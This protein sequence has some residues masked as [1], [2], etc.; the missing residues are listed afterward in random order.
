M[1]SHD[2][3]YDLDGSTTASSSMSELSK[4]TDFEDSGPPTR[5][6]FESRIKTEE[7]ADI[8]TEESADQEE[9]RNATAESSDDVEI[10]RQRVD[11]SVDTF[12]PPKYQPHLDDRPF[13]YESPLGAEAAE[14]TPITSMEPSSNNTT[15]DERMDVDVTSV[16]SPPSTLIRNSSRPS[17]SQSAPTSPTRPKMFRSTS[18]SNERRGEQDLEMA[19]ILVGMS[20]TKH[21]NGKKG[22]DS[23]QSSKQSVTSSV[24]I[25]KP[26]PLNQQPMLCVT[27]GYLRVGPPIHGQALRFFN[28]PPPG[29]LQALQQPSLRAATP[30]RKIPQQSKKENH[31]RSPQP[32]PPDSP[33]SSRRDF[34]EPVKREIPRDD[35]TRLFLQEKI[36][37]E[38][39]RFRGKRSIS[40]REEFDEYKTNT[41]KAAKRALMGSNPFNIG[42]KIPDNFLLHQEKRIYQGHNNKLVMGAMK[43]FADSLN[44]KPPTG[45]KGKKKDELLSNGGG[46]HVNNTNTPYDPYK[47]LAELELARSKGFP[48]HA[49]PVMQQPLPPGEPNPALD[50]YKTSEDLKKYRESTL[51]KIGDEARKPLP[52]PEMQSVVQGMK[53]MHAH[54]P[55]DVSYEDNRLPP[56][57]H[58][59]GRRAYAPPEGS[60]PD[61]S[62]TSVAVTTTVNVFTSHPHGISSIFMP[63]QQ[64][65]F[66]Y[67]H[68]GDPS[69]SPYALPPSSMAGVRPGKKVV[70]G[71]PSYILPMHVQSHQDRPQLSASVPI[72]TMNPM[73]PNP[74]SRPRPPVSHTSYGNGPPSLPPSLPRFDRRPGIMFSGEPRL[75]VSTPQYTP[76][77]TIRSA[78]SNNMQYVS[79]IFQQLEKPGK[80]A[81][82]INNGPKIESVI[83]FGGQPPMSVT[84]IKKERED[85]GDCQINNNN[86]KDKE[87]PVSPG[88]LFSSSSEP[89]LF[90]QPQARVTERQICREDLKYDKKK[91]MIGKV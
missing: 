72:L 32:P 27:S 40:F 52:G 84:N 26:Y 50:P 35:K 31:P 9:V 34:P 2:P 36:N 38:R 19:S 21:L 61:L 91:D 67:S 87:G 22:A 59:E 63:M 18:D 20:Q 12:G 11:D 51:L 23:G 68:S 76:I 24:S 14:T 29:Q 54:S 44:E 66:P 77:Q 62:S 64:V 5:A 33:D 15:T 73:N 28:Q 3:D 79:G 83:S 65:R 74:Y 89:S 46:K 75:A 16:A 37:K 88:G 49:P 85:N 48:Q 1:S 57:R 58:T 43:F 82:D 7:I 70:A 86:Q 4:R 10:I 71:Y 45:S 8:K 55:K 30:P 81:R 90:K 56:S 53:D 78:E 17:Q 47:T 80:N 42:M 25:A 60:R 39:D 13:K 41:R 69:Q 6:S